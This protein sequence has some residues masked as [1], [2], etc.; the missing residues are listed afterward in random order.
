MDKWKLFGKVCKDSLD[1]RTPEICKD[2]SKR[3]Y[4]TLTL[5][6]ADEKSVA[7]APPVGSAEARR[8]PP[9]RS[10]PLRP[11]RTPRPSL[12]PLQS[13]ATGFRRNCE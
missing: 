12:Q 9:A 3:G 10:R 5:P 11:P 6:H 2:F 7:A 13:P 1:A 4:T 8:P